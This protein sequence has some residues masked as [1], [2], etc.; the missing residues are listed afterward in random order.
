MSEFYRKYF[1]GW[2][3]DLAVLGGLIFLVFLMLIDYNP[4][5][6]LAGLVFLFILVPLPIVNGVWIPIR[7]G[8]R[9]QSLS[10]VQLREMLALTFLNEQD[11]LTEH[12]WFIFLRSILPNLV[13]MPFT[14]CFMLYYEKSTELFVFLFFPILW[15]GVLLSIGICGVLWGF[16]RIVEGKS[17]ISSYYGLSIGYTIG[18]GAV[19]LFFIY[20][21]FR[22]PNLIGIYLNEQ[23][24]FFLFACLLFFFEGTLIYSGKKYWKRILKSYFYFE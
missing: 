1:W 5:A 16:C 7:L 22:I 19:F 8:P 17:R 15:C 14:L 4:N 10:D 11:Y 2:F 21:F 18:V 20:L 24:G 23:L 6:F 9:I 13:L 12:L 3:W